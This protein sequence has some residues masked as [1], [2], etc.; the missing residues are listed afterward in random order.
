MTRAL[1]VLSSHAE[2]GST[3]RPTGF[4]L[5]EAAH[6]HRLF[7]AAGWDVDFVSP[8][9]GRP[10]MD[11]V[12]L[13]D[14]VQRAFLDDPRVAAALADTPTPDQ[15]DPA[16]HDVVFYAGGHGTMWDFPDNPV[17][18]GIAARLYEAGG[19]VGAVCHGPAG[20]VDVRLS[21]GSH[22]VAGKQVAS[23]TDD[24][25]RAVGLDEVVPFLLQTRLTQRGARHSGA[26]NFQPHV[27]VDDR[28]VTGQN[29]AS[30][31]GVAERIV[32][33]VTARGPRADAP[34]AGS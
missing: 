14:P 6:P 11:G 24:E 1:I 10:P 22:L 27:V 2:L 19:V 25:E 31:V 8:Q 28:L 7:T 21:D 17:L 3:G 20:L 32:A 9:G 12:D 16:D 30:A 18:A 15:I 5:P 34:A 13:S 4:Y 23:F 29:P 26:P 33:L